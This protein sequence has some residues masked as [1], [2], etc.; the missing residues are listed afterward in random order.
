MAYAFRYG[1]AVFYHPEIEL[2]I[3]ESLD[4]L[5]KVV[6]GVRHVLDGSLALFIGHAALGLN[7]SGAEERDQC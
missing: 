5:K 4:G 6:L 7:E 2:L 3:A 1:P